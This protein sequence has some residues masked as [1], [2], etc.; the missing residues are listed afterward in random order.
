MGIYV[1]L[2]S[3]VFGAE[4]PG[5]VVQFYTPQT[6]S[7]EMAAGTSWST[8]LLIASRNLVAGSRTD[9]R[10][11]VLDGGELTDQIHHNYR[12][13]VAR[14]Y[15]VVTFRGPPV[16]STIKDK[17]GERDV[18]HIVVGLTLPNG[19][20]EYDVDKIYTI[21]RSNPLLHQ[22]VQDDQKKRDAF[23]RALRAIVQANDK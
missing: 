1:V 4:D 11:L 18:S 9:P 7:A 5:F 19:K 22:H 23:I 8:E 20:K 16:S 15:L 14:E 10:E 13:S 3:A 12:A 6:A 2:L 21:D 17:D